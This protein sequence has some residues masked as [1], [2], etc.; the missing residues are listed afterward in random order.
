MHDLIIIGGGCAGIGA[1]IYAVRYNLKT[2]IISKEMGGVLNEA[3]VVEN[4]P[5]FRS[6]S[7][8]D[9][10][11]KFREHAQGLGVEFF[12]GEVEK[13]EKTGRGFLIASKGNKFES[14]A[15]ILAFGLKRRHLNILNEDK[16]A[17]KGISYCYTCD[18]PFCKNKTVA[19]VGGSDSAALAALL[20]AQYAKKVYIIYR[21][22]EIRAEPINKK[23]VDENKKIEIINNTNVVEVRGDKFLS[24]VL[25]DRPYNGSKEFGLDY[26]FIE[27]GSVPSIVIAEQLGVR[28]NENSMIVVDKEKKTNVEGVFAAGDITDTVM[29]Q[30]ITAAADG[31]IASLGAYQ[32]IKKKKLE[33]Y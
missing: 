6:I 20:L 17:G 21:K 31:A 10:M 28:L 7:G 9:L 18:A 30:A 29:R 12:D 5:G 32:H 23:A 26:L 24:S 19:V 1:G 8:I 33:K 13:A 11:V 16:F 2:L 4:Y 22:E 27:A 14:K 3:H 15:L 25:L